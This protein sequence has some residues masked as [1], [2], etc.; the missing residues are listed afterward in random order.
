[1]ILTKLVSRATRLRACNLALALATLAGVCAFAPQKA[2]AGARV[3]FPDSIAPGTIVISAHQRRLYLVN[4][5]GTAISYPIAVP[6][7]GKEWSGSTYV[8][9]KQDHPDWF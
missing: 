8:S 7:R 1:M 5:D 9:A 3:S 2:E 6:K 4:G